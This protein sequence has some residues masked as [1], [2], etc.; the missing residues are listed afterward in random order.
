MK[1]KGVENALLTFNAKY[2]LANEGG[3]EGGRGRGGGRGAMKHKVNKGNR[4]A[5]G[6]RGGG[7]GMMKHKVNEGGGGGGEGGEGGVGG[8]TVMKQ[9]GNRHTAHLHCHIFLGE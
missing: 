7:R 3:G 1:H 9:G 5:G 4:G 6:R 8:G 2:F